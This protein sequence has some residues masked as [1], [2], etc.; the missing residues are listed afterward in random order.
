MKISPRAF[1]LIIAPVV[2]L[3]A[4]TFPSDAASQ[5]SFDRTLRVSGPVDLDVQTGAGSISVRQ[6]G[7]ATVEVHAVIRISGWGGFGDSDARVH[8]LESHP[9]IEQNGN[10]I[11]IGHVPNHDLTRNISISYQLTVPAETKLHSSSGSGSEDIEGIRG[12]VDAGSGSGAITLADIGSEIHAHTGSGSITLNSIHGTA[13]ASTGSGSIHATGIAGGFT[14]HTGSGTV[15]VQQTAAGDV[16]VG[17]GSGSIELAGA[18]G[19]VR[20]HAGSGNISAQ[21]SPK[22]E[23]KLWTGSG[24][25]QVSFPPR[26]AY[27]LVA[28]TGSGSIYTTQ[29]IEVQGAIGKHD[30]H[31][32]VHGGGSTVD[33]STG[34]GSIRID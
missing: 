27:D 6:G 8:Y 28:H 3:A 5:G 23:W 13:Q 12:P 20:A 22:G 19:A 30:V 18:D 9:P 11:S 21:G 31:G 14:G 17:T 16:N 26:A 25:L 10:T 33:L 29:A 32:K 15:H 1:P 34:S 2:F 24:S 4:C 7:P